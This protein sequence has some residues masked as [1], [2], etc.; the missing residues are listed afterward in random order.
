MTPT[1]SPGVDSGT[2]SS[3]VQAD[4]ATSSIGRKREL[5]IRYYHLV[6]RKNARKSIEGESECSSHVKDLERQACGR[7]NLR[8][9]KFERVAVWHER[10]LLNLEKIAFDE[11]RNV[12]A[13]A[14]V[15][16]HLSKF[17]R[18]GSHVWVLTS[19][20]AGLTWV[21]SHE[22]CNKFHEHLDSHWCIR[23][24]RF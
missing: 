21:A 11:G 9:L 5:G 13:Y 8:E 18:L 1:D 22:I 15:S 12:D 17:S 2:E 23:R 6:R 3:A 16:V 20:F 24:K 10:A 14:H 19:G 4:V 7:G